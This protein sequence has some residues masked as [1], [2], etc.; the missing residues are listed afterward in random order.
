MILP[1]TMEWMDKK[2]KLELYLK[3]KEETDRDILNCFTR[4]DISQETY[5]K[6]IASWEEWFKEFL[7]LLSADPN[8]WQTE[9]DFN[10]N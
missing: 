5:C 1:E 7:K 10:T 9:L 8:E 2:E 4:W 3:L 6:F